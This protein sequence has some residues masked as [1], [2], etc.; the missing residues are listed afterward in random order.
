MKLVEP[1][2]ASLV[3]KAL[4]KASR[5]NTSDN[6]KSSLTISTIRIPDM[7]A[8]TFRLESA[9][10]MAALSGS[11]KPRASAITA[12]VDAVPITAQW[13]RLRDIQ[14]SATFISSS[15][16]RPARCA[17]EKRQTSEVAISFPWYLPISITPPETT[18]VGISTLHAPIINTK[19]KKT[20]PQNNTTPTNK[21]TQKNTT[22]AM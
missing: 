7:W 9:A 5:V 15:L 12:M 19:K 21:K 11:V 6:F 16:M 20:Q 2:M 14:A 13:P 18:I 10:G 8:N 1:P 4:S 3:M 17:S 22:T